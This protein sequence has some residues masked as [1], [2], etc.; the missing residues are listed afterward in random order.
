MTDTP[1]SDEQ[2]R[3]DDAARVAEGDAVERR[4][5]GSP[6]TVQ[7]RSSVAEGVP[8]AESRGIYRDLDGGRRVVGAG[9]PI[10]DGWERIESAS[11]ADRVGTVPTAQDEDDEATSSGGASESSPKPKRGRG[12]S[13]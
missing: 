4:A 6:A 3:A 2:V 1:R 12:S 5:I 11:I 9:D 13:S 8:R 7:R 10:P